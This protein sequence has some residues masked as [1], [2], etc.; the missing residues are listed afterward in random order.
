MIF[1]SVIRF[2]VCVFMSF[3][4]MGIGNAQEYELRTYVG[5]TYYLGDLAPFTHT[6]STS[7]GKLA[8]GIS[9]G[10]KF[11]EVFTLSFKYLNG[12]LVGDDK[13]AND[14]TRRRRNLN[15]VSDIHEYGIALDIYLTTVIPKLHKYGLDFYLAPAFNIFKFNPKTE[16]Q[17]EMVELQPLGTEG[18]GVDEF[19]TKDKYKLIQPSF[20]LGLGFNFKLGDKIRLGF[21]LV[22]RMTFTDYLDDVSGVYISTED[23]KQLQGDLTTALANRKG[24]YIF[25]INSGEVEPVLT[26]E[27]R[28]DGRDNDWYLMTLSYVSYRFG[29][30]VAEKEKLAKLEK[31]QK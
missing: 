7:Q 18:Q 28:G 23:Q 16:Y 30:P 3:M 17:G 27:Q 22:P 10:W 15:F 1:K 29:G 13:N 31:I 4:T 14:V 2:V 5:A 21:E 9:I 6:L 12:E 25:G 24:E 19:G 26:G 11:D 20:A 8:K